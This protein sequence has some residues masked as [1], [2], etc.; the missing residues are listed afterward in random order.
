M[1][2]C[3]TLAYKRDIDQ[4]MFERV[5]TPLGIGREDLR[6]RKNQYREHEIN[7]VGR[8]E[9]GSGIHANVNAMARIG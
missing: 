7:G 2:E 9:V 6:W 3:V 8:R 1:A 5:F 4:L